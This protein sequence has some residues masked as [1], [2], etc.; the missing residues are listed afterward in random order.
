MRSVEFAHKI[1][2]NIGEILDDVDQ[3]QC[4]DLILAILES[5]RI[6]LA[7]VGRSKR[8]IE[9]FAMRLM[10]LGFVVYVVGETVTPAITANDML[11]IGSNSGETSTLIVLT[12]KARSVGT[13]VAVI[14]GNTTSTLASL[15]KLLI[16][17]PVEKKHQGKKRENWQPGGNAFEQSLLILLDAI[18]LEMAERSGK[19]IST[20]LILHANLE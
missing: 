7:G 10:H 11:I 2:E 18:V 16:H 12:E 14:T 17:I 19:D 20:K 9:S 13:K 3:S 15:A 8:V 6:F 4:E 5:K 1:V